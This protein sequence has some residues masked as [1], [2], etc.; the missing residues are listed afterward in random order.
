M[1]SVRKRS[2]SNRPEPDAGRNVRICRL[3]SVGQTEVVRALSGDDQSAVERHR[4][5]STF[6]EVADLY[7]RVR[8]RYPRA[9][10][11]DL[12][13]AAKLRAGD[14]VLEIGAGTWAG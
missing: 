12:F 7:D 6:D 14:R 10:F 3:A 4:L 8:P 2:Q 13:T 11:D 1:Q 9:L 5:A